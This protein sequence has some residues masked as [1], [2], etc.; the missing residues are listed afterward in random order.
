MVK[1]SEPIE[2]LKTFKEPKTAVR[3]VA[4]MMD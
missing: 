1:K 2:E 3:K 4:V